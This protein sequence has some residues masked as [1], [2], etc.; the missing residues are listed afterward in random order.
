M[1]SGRYAD[2]GRLAIRVGRHGQ[3][4]AEW[5]PIH[6]SNTERIAVPDEDTVRIDL[7]AGMSEILVKIGNYKGGYGFFLRITDEHGFELP[8]MQWVET[9]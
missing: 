4:L 7:P 8:G 9:G 6:S 3:G 1:V 5:A 2:G